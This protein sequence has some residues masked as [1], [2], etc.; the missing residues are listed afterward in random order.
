[1]SPLE[2]HQMER[3][4]QHQEKYPE[5]EVAGVVEFVLIRVVEPSPGQGC[6]DPLTQGLHDLGAHLFSTLLLLLHLL[7]PAQV[8]RTDGDDE[9]AARLQWDGSP[10]THAAAATPPCWSD[11]A[12]LPRPLPHA[13][14]VSPT[15]ARACAVSHA[16][17]DPCVVAILILT[18]SSLSVLP[19]LLLLLLH[20]CA[21]S[22][23]PPPPR[24]TPPLLHA[25]PLL[26]CEHNQ[27]VCRANNT[28]RLHCA[29]RFV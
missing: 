18:C 16:G 9:A 28:S 23:P 7:L 26:K 3:Q 27:E 11:V 22:T 4:G 1:M 21:A 2:T 8:G 13:S 6:P 12:R 19:L 17:V 5:I 15:D 14:S 29:W 25:H 20:R 24:F 10:L